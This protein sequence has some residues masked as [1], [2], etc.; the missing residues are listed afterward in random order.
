MLMPKF[1]AGIVPVLSEFCL[2]IIHRGWA[3]NESQKLRR[4]EGKAEKERGNGKG[5]ASGRGSKR[6]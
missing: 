2:L 6:R 4:K 1:T 5:T 3:N